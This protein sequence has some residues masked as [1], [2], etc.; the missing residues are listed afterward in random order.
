[1]IGILIHQSDFGGIFESKIKIPKAEALDSKKT[2]SFGLQKNPKLKLWTP[3][4]PKAEAL[5]SKKT[6]S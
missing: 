5:D 1:M 4:K 6:Q 2:Q 3:K